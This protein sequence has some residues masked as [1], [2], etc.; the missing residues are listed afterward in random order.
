MPRS[1][2]VMAGV[3]RVPHAGVAHQGHVG[4]QFPR[5]GGEEGRKARRSAFLLPLQQ[6]GNVH[7]QA[8]VDVAVG[9][10]RLQEGEDLSLVVAGAARH[11]PLVPA[12]PVTK[13]GSK[14]GDSH[15]SSGSTGCTS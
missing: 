7:R 6:D 13:A 12:G 11:D 14:G 4:G 9:A 2:V 5:M 15:K 8:A 10:Q 3:A 1:A